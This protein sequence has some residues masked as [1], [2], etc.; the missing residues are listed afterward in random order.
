MRL[1]HRLQSLELKFVAQKPGCNVTLFIVVPEDRK[2][3]LFDSDSYRPSSVEIEIFLKKLKDGGECR[4]CKGSCSI[5]WSPDGFNNHTLGGAHLAS[6]P[7]PNLLLIFCA[8]VEI[9]VL[10]RQLVNGGR[11]PISDSVPQLNK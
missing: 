1:E 7:G 9:P 5:D 8:D 10:C 3:E 2:N 4:N 6:V 11:E